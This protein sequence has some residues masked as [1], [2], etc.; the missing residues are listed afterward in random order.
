MNFKLE[1]DKLNFEPT[2]DYNNYYNIHDDAIIHHVYKN[3]EF[4]KLRKKPSSFKKWD[5]IC[6]TY[7]LQTKQE[8]KTAINNLI[9]FDSLEIHNFYSPEKINVREAIKCDLIPIEVFI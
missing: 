4:K 1:M 2:C 8:L 7:F 6:T 9:K 5:E 3:Q